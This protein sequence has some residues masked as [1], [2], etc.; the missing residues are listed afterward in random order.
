MCE[1]HAGYCFCCSPFILIAIEYSTV[2]ISL[3][4]GIWVFGFLGSG[5]GGYDYY[6]DEHSRGV[7]RS[8]FLC[9]SIGCILRSGIAKAGM[10]V[11]AFNFRTL[12]QM[13]SQ[14]GRTHLHPSSNV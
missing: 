9:M 4:Q 5:W 2:W 10:D 7:F 13:I 3:L 6:C 12:C 1:I 14:S 11:N 8:T